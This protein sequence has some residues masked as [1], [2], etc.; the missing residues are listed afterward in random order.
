[1]AEKME[2]DEPTVPD[3][4]KKKEAPTKADLDAITYE[5]L[6]DW[7]TQLERGEVHIVGRVMQFLAKTRKELNVE[8]LTKLITTFISE[9]SLRDFLLS[10]VA[11]NHAGSSENTLMDVDKAKGGTRSPRPDRRS[12]NPPPKTTGN[13]EVELY[14]QLLTFLYLLDNNKLDD[15]EQVAQNYIARIDQFERRSLDSFLAKGFFYLTLVAERQNRIAELRGYLNSRLRVATLRN[16]T[17]T[18]ATLIVCLLRVFLVTKNYSA[19]SKLLT[20]VSFPEAANNNDLARFLYY[21]GRIRAVELDYNGAS[22]FFH[23]SLR[24]A[25]QDSAIG[26]KQNVQKW[27]VVI[28]LLLGQI[29]ERSVFRVAAFKKPLAA[30]LELTHAVRL[31]DIIQFNKV[32]ENFKPVFTADETITLIV[33]LRQNV[34]KTAIRQISLAYSRIFV[35]DIAKKLGMISAVDAEYMV[36]KAVKEGTINAIVSFDSLADDRYMQTVESENLYRSTEPQFSYDE[37]IKHCLVLHNQAVKA[38]RFPSDKGKAGIESIEQQRERELMELEF[39][40]EMAE[41]D[42]DDF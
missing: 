16:Q 25:P 17:D 29:P 2:V 23:Q 12:V 33:R 32:V 27:V 21:Q 34:I 22:Q 37:R 20:K 3:S 15:V 42:D 24:K 35:K 41:E 38:L 26:F 14:I 40:K 1:M 11:P 39:A 31:G 5:N 10:F 18:I 30:Y 8:I 6:K 9:K 36:T 13:P 7:C 28:Q 19:A 4:E